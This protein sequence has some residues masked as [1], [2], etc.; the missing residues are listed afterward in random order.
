MSGKRLKKL[1]DEKKTLVFPGTFNPFTAKLIESEGFD[2]IYISGAA[3][4]NSLGVPDDGSLS[5]DDFVYAA[6][7]ICKAVGVP[8]ICDADTGFGNISGTVK[9][10]I[11]SGLAGMHIEDQ[12]FPKRCGHLS[13]KEVIPQEEM[14]EK[15]KEATCS[16]DETDR[17]FLIIAR[18]DAR[19]AQNIDEKN[20][21]DESIKRGNSYLEAG[22]DMIFPE[23]LK[24]IEEFKIY[25]N[26]VPG[27]LLANMTEFGKTPFI[28]YRE[29]ENIGY[30]LVIFPVSLFRFS[31]GRMR[32]ALKVIKKDGNQ[33]NLTIGMM[34]RKKINDLINYNPKQED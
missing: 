4:T 11:E 20:Q 16:R 30:N 9:K 27:L 13:G 23:S 10:Y 8:V 28:S 15:I 3:L 25:R 33:E 6:K 21:L 12:V 29:F 22:A 18:T 5:L 14:I 7:W 31:A 32:E 2:G 19:G 17:D 34:T 26:A 24:S 1:L